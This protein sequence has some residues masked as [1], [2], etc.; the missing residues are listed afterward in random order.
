MFGSVR[1]RRRRSERGRGLFFLGE[2]GSGKGTGNIPKPFERS[3]DL[4]QLPTVLQ[5]QAAHTMGACT[6]LEKEWIELIK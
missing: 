4:A 6:D 1:S 3:D 5:C 2:S